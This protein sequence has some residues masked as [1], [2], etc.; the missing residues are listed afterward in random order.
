MNSP[1]I[2]HADAADW[3][4]IQD[5]LVQSRLP[6][7]GAREHLENFMVAHDRSGLLAC[8]G[9]ELYPPVALLR[10]VAVAETHRGK[11][12]GRSLTTRL[13]SHAGNQGIQTLVLL[14]ETAEAYFLKLGFKP[15]PRASL[16]PEVQDSAELRGAC[17]A[18][19]TAMVLSIGGHIR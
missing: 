6:L 3:Q 19:A 14:T 4:A 2:R 8:A 7:D 18:S 1:T 13:I 17:P 15:V 5:L 9:L 10:S 16:P 12:L 11:G